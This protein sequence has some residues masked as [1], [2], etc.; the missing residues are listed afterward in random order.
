MKHSATELQNL[1]TAAEAPP[2]ALTALAAL[3][4]MEL[5]GRADC[6]AAAGDTDAAIAL[7]QG[8][9]NGATSPL[10]P[11][12]QFNLGVLLSQASR[13][14]EA[15]EAYRGAIMA[16]PDLAQAWFNLGAVVER[17]GRREQAVAIWAS[18]IDRPLA[19][20]D[21]ERELYL[22]ILNG[23]GRVLEDLRQFD[24]AEDALYRSLLAEPGQPHVI[25]HWVHLRQKQCKWPA[26][27]SIPGVSRGDMIKGA[28]PLAMLATTDDTGLQLAAAIRFVNDK[29]D[30][31]VP[32][33]APAGGY[34]HDRLRLGFLSSD[35]CLHAVSLLTVQLL[36]LLPRDR[37]EIYGFCW[38]RED[39]TALRQR[40]VNAFDHY[41]RIADMDDGQAARAIRE[42]EIDVVVDLQG[43]TSGARPNII[44]HRPAPV[45]MT[46]LGFPGP[47]GHP[48]IDYVVAD[49][50]LIPDHEAPLYT[51]K[52]LYLP[53]IFQCSD[54]ERPV[55]ALP[56]R[57]ECGLPEDGF[58]FCCFNNNYK[59][60]EDV[61]DS[62]MRIL[63]AVPGS[64]LW[65]LADNPWSQQNMTERA[66]ARGV[67]VSRLIFAP[68]VSPEMYLA[69]YTAADLFLDAFPFNAGTTANDALWMGLP[70]L[71]RLGRAFAS[72]MAGSLLRG[73]GL[74]DLVTH[75]LVEYEELAIQIAVTPGRIDEI[76]QRLA[77]GRDHSPVF[78]MPRFVQDFGDAVERIAVRA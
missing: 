9:L 68:R 53:D 26:F 2:T 7:Y 77:H 35:F 78:D 3:G 20:P 38:S 72:R 65:L 8:W 31:R 23:M 70:V 34:R 1:A 5:I 22:M 51:E 33:L 67:D 40:V 37:F 15:E 16:K 19:S 10:R 76:K 66:R 49:R 13:L 62:W 54:R 4:P 75:S 63:H 73:L 74:P 27:G 48:C 30:L 59:F 47:T 69:R 41:I 46:Y 28:S 55:G 64:V 6:L 36:E 45:Q 14:A 61:F 32:R 11:V 50:Y 39:G 18:M 44:A 43:I 29:V 25:Q 42:H 57:A 24:R 58:V 56:G 52:P 60:T 17:Q 12:V 71:T 21:H